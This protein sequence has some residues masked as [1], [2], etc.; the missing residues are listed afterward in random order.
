MTGLGPKPAVNQCARIGV[1]LQAMRKGTAVET[2]LR[3]SGELADLEAVAQSWFENGPDIVRP[4]CRF[5][6][7]ASA[8]TRPPL[9]PVGP[10]DHLSACLRR[11]E[12]SAA[13]GAV[14]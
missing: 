4:R 14:V 3:K 8:H 9:E 7:D 5:A 12:I 6:I 13:A 11:H 1:P 10:T 2:V